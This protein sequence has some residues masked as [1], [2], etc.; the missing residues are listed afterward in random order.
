[1]LGYWRNWGEDGNFSYVYETDYYWFITS[2]MNICEPIRLERRNCKAKLQCLKKGRFGQ[3][4]SWGFLSM[5]L[6]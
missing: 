3:G 6:L 5:V 4:T 2:F 1:M